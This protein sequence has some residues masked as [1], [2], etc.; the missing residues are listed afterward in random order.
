MMKDDARMMA[1][2][3]MCRRCAMSCQE[4]TNMKMA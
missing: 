3:E 2:A 1:C 4:M